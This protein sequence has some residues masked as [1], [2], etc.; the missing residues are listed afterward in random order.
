[1]AT[2]TLPQPLVLFRMTSDRFCELPPS[3][4]VKLELLAGEVVVMGRPTRDHQYFILQLAFAIEQW[5]KPRKLGRLIAD[6]LMKLDDEWTPAPDLVFVARKHLRR[7][8]EKR[9][10]GPVDLAVEALSPGNP[11]IDRET[12][13]DAYA[14]FGIS[15]YWIVDLKK[16]VLEEYELIG[17]TYGNLVEAPFDRPFKPRLFPG[18]VIDL[19]PLEW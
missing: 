9:I 6:I 1:M 8:K 17:D 15:W 10:E 13:F 14:R 4:T 5:N 3:D 2:A 16:R 12:K 7:V 18:L 19:A 11:E